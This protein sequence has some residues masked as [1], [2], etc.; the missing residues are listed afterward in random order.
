MMGKFILSSRNT[1]WMA[2]FLVLAVYACGLFIPLMDYDSSHHADIALHMHLTGNYAFLIDNGQPYLD[3]PHLLFWLA[4]FAYKIFGVTGFAYRLPSFLFSLLAIYSTYRL[5]SQLYNVATGKLAGL[6]LSTAFAFAVSIYDVRMEG[7]LTGSVIFATWQLISYTRK[8]KMVHLLLSALG[9]ATGFATKGMIGVVIPVVALLA[10]LIYTRQWKVLF[11]PAWAFVVI[12]FGLFISPVVYAYYLQFDLHPET[13]VKG[14]DNISGVKFILWDQSFQRMSGE[15]HGSN[16]SD[17]FFFFHTYFWVF[18]P[19]S[20]LGFYAILS[21]CNSFIKTKFQPVSYLPEA[22]SIVTA[23]FFM[24]L[25]SFSK[26][27]LPHYLNCLLPFFSILLAGYLMEKHQN[28]K[29]QKRHWITQLVISILTVTL[30]LFLTLWAFPVAEPLKIAVLLLLFV[31]W[32]S[33]FFR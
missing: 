10:H 14:H 2:M 1:V 27:K 7:L 22:V 28:E 32:L 17:F 12:L 9:L 15:S 16:K 19:W 8:R 6:I 25:F 24:F 20:M 33:V 13:T 18:L 30:G 4:S 31:L 23:L 11:D 3:K 26:F 21:R 5:A 29:I